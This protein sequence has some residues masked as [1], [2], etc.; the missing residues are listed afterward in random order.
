MAKKLY[1]VM[2]KMNGTW[3]PS[4]GIK[5]YIRAFEKKQSAE[6]S[7]KRLLTIVNGSAV[8]NLRK[9][10]EFEEVEDE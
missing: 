4:V 7:M 5:G 10:V 6:R 9:V 8:D 3:Y 2:E 1:V